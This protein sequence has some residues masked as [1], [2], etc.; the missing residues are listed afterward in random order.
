MQIKYSPDAL[1]IKLKEGKPVDAIDISENIILHL[2]RGKEPLEIEILDASKFVALDD[3]DVS[4]K[5]LLGKRLKA[6]VLR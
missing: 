5:G 2:A 3:I 6:P 4:W 1:V